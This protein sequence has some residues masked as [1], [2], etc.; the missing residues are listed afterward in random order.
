MLLIALLFAC[1]TDVAY[2]RPQ[3][4]AV[5]FWPEC[6]G[7]GRYDSIQ[8]ETVPTL[9]EYNADFNNYRCDIDAVERKLWCECSQG[10]NLLVT[11]Y[12]WQ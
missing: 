2:Y 1:D 8:L 9:I 6:T 7:P 10:A 4:K 11:A 12:S 3:M 5:E